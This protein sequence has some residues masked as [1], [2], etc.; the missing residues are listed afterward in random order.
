[1]ILFKHRKKRG[2]FSLKDLRD[3]EALVESFCPGISPKI[4]NSISN[5]RE[6][7][8][9]HICVARILACVRIPPSWQSG[10]INCYT[11]GSKMRQNTGTELQGGGKGLAVFELTSRSRDWTVL[12]RFFDG[13]PISETG[14]R[15][16]FHKW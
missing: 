7:G 8:F 6:H 4:M 14:G 12:R 3:T 1:M 5:K 2:R 15:D 11:D 10:C 16:I 9:D 13:C